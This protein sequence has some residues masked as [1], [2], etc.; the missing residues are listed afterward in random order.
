MLSLYIQTISKLWNLIFGVIEEDAGSYIPS[1]FL[2]K[3]SFITLKFFTE[4][5]EIVLLN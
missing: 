4:Y 1:V 3:S 5:T 2:D